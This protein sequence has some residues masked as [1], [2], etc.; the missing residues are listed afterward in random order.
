[1]C[2]RLSEIVGV[3][4]LATGLAVAQDQKDLPDGAGKENLQ[5]VCSN[6]HDL[7]AVTGTR[8][9]KIGWQ[10][11]IEDMVGRGAEGSED[12][13]AAIVA[14]L[15]ANF[16]KLNVNTASAQEIEKMLEFTPKEAQAIVE[17]REKNGKIAGF[18]QLKT[19]PGLSAEKLQAKR[20]L[21]AF[22]L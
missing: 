2:V 9:T 15:T 18:E 4:L 3:V 14:Y 13:M 12:D 5:R 21:I 19:V 16:G 17:F 11:M 6:C 22:S 7:E 20:P 8:R 10:R 1:M